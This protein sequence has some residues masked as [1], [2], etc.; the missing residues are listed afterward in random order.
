MI[1]FRDRP[2]RR[3]LLLLTLAPTVA[4]LLLASIGFL[5]WDIVERRREI[6]QDVE[7]E[8]QVL[9]ET[10]APAITFNRPEEIDGFL[11]V[12]K[13]R[14][15]VRFACVYSLDGERVGMFHRDGEPGC[16]TAPPAGSSFGWSRYQVVSPVTDQGDVVGTFYLS[17]DMRDVQRRLTVGSGIILGLLVLAVALALALAQRMRRSVSEPLLGLAETAR[18]ISTTRDYAIRATPLSR[19]EIGVVVRSFNEM[20][21]HIA[22]RSA[23]LSKANAELQHEVDERKRVE[24]E[25]VAALERE[26]EA[27]RL[28]DEFLATLSHELRTPLNAV[29]GWARV[30]R[31]TSADEATQARGLESIER[32]A[33]AQ[34][35]LIEDLLEISRIVTGKLRLHVREVDLAAIVDTAVDIVKPAALAKRLQLEAYIDARPAL[36]QGDP[37]RLQQVVWNLLSNAVK[38]TLPEGRVTVRLTR[39]DGYVLTVQD[40]GAGIEPTF[41]PHVFDAFRQADGSA[42]REHGG[43][44]LGLAIARQL[45]EA[46]GGTIQAQSEGRDTGSTFEVL[47]PSVVE[48]PQSSTVFTEAPAMEPVDASLLSGVDVLVVDDD[49]DARVLL[50]MT[51]RR[52]GAEVVMA[53]SAREALAAIDRALPDVVLSD[54]G[55]PHQDGYDLLR[56]LR[57]RPAE[58][59]GR[60][61]AVAVTAYA[62]ATDRS[63]T[64]A[65]GYQAHVAKPYEPDEIARLVRRLLASEQPAARGMD[66]ASSLATDNL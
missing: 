63:S 57:A 65:A 36:T 48:A 5:T 21:D 54:I 39:K 34:A 8:A 23:Q 26:R 30:L 6:R 47:L 59:G 14:P 1:P 44:G 22:D 25:R 37:D 28:K 66:G 7:I 4:A 38:F 12:L 35:R 55:M 46:H 18:R 9:P 16:G 60:I 11:A 17:R 19:D 64:Q 20:L 45:V 62:S 15:H 10:V 49:E 32:N 29:L 53:A 33:R 31:A 27:N 3:K 52:Y 13:I 43:L 58:Q 61:P 40:S 2:I 51:L 41:L 24:G 42:T 50:Q 56:Q